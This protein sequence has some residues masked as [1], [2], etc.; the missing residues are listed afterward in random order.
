LS[1]GEI[2]KLEKVA[3]SY[4]NECKAMQDAKNDDRRKKKD[5]K[6]NE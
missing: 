6:K 1:W 2:A 3:E 4:Q 5:A